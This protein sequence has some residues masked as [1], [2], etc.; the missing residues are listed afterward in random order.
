M[1]SEGNRAGIKY[2]RDSL[3]DIAAIAQVK[4]VVVIA[5]QIWSRRFRE[6]VVNAKSIGA[7]VAP[8]L[9]CQ[10]KYAPKRELVSQ[11]WLVRFV[12][13]VTGRTVPARVSLRRIVK[14]R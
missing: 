13:F 6:K 7:I 4:K 14:H 8:P 1:I 2:G 5:Q 3:C 10:T 11:P 12:V 9:A